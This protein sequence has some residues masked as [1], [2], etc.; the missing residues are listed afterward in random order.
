VNDK[1][2]SISA[3]SAYPCDLPL[4]LCFK[5]T[6]N[7]LLGRKPGS[8]SLL[9]FDYRQT[10]PVFMQYCVVNQGEVWEGGLRPCRLDIIAAH[11]DE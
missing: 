7:L 6:L 10:Q 11:Q 1:G 2:E 8:A 5:T 4:E 3:P 9:R